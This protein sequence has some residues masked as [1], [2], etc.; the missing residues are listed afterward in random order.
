[1]MILGLWPHSQA[2]GLGNG[3]CQ[4]IA[5]LFPVGHYTGASV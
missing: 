4:G 3:A 2:E 1:M 5:S